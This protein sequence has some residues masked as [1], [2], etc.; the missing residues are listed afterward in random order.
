MREK[1]YRIIFFTDTR[2][3][4]NF[5]LWLLYLILI[6]F[7]VVVMESIP[8]LG[9]K[10]NYEFYLIEWFFT[11]LF[12][13]E[14]LLRILTSPLPLRYVFSFWGFI[15]LIAILS[16][17]LSLFIN[18]Y[19]YL[20]GIRIIRLIRVFRILKLTRFSGEAKTLTL[21][22]Q[23]SAYKIVVFMMFMMVMVIILGTIM[24]VIEADNPGF[25]SI[26]Q[27][28]YWAIVTVTTVGFGDVVPI[29]VAGKMLASFT[30]L[31]GYVIIAVPTGIT[32]IEFHRASKES[33]GKK[34][35]EHCSRINRKDA[36]YCYH[37]GNQFE[38]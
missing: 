14:Y 10:Y 9:E 28:I 5:D 22:I 15:D 16:G 29:T 24:Y 32:A 23:N 4:R 33:D 8:E 35:C 20:Q 3:G 12:S 6:N 1:I 36:R 37:C 25:S 17:Y 21:A 27:S 13:L 7:L 26:P 34:D 30:M 2:A 31:I 19:H 11:G 38:E 18:S